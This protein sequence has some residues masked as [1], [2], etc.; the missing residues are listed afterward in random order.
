VVVDNEHILQECKR[1]TSPQARFSFIIDYHDQYCSADPSITR[2][3]FYRYSDALWR[4]LNPPTHYQSRLRHA[5]SQAI[6][7]SIAGAVLAAIDGA[8]MGIVVAMLMFS[9]SCPRISGADRP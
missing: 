3:N 5:I 4:F 1:L 6:F 8:P 9:A 7:M 2:V